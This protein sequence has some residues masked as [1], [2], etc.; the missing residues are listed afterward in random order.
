MQPYPQP[1]YDP[2]FAQPSAVGAQPVYQPG[3]GVQP[4]LYPTQQGLYNTQP[5]VPA[6]F[7]YQASWMPTALGYDYK[8]PALGYHVDPTMDPWAL[9]GR[10]GWPK[11]YPA[12]H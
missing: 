1:G 7:Q 3:V 4:G 5:Y 10:M 2:R 9:V 6:Y 8:L 12:Q 11:Y